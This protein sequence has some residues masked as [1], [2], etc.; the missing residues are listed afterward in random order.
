MACVVVTVALLGAGCGADRVTDP[1][2]ATTCVE[3]VDAGRATAEKVLAHLGDRTL[4]EFEAE[5]PSDPF[6]GLDPLLRPD[7]FASRAVELGCRDWRT[8]PEATWHGPTWRP[9][10]Q[11]ATDPR[12]AG[13]SG[14]ARYW[15][16][17][18]VDRY[19]GERPAGSPCWTTS[20]N[21]GE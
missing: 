14:R 19:P 18:S 16:T 13:S 7:V 17:W 3:L 8:L 9:T 12:R 15:P 5:D 1:A 20:G 10:S 6:G 2:R 4:A 21:V 11:P